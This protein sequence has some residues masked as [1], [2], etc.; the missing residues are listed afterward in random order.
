MLSFHYL[1]PKHSEMALNKDLFDFFIVI[2]NFCYSRYFQTWNI[3][4]TARLMLDEERVQDWF[5]SFLKYRT[6]V[7][8][9]KDQYSGFGHSI[10]YPVKYIEGWYIFSDYL[11]SIP[12]PGCCHRR[13][14]IPPFH[15]RK[16]VGSP[17]K[18]VNC[19]YS[20]FM[21]FLKFR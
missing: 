16:R 21:S 6:S 11:K 14:Q 10:S 15:S 2:F 19:L 8:I 17:L 3:L 5:L 20:S 18:F 1:L 9:W 4:C 7:N 13:D 12:D